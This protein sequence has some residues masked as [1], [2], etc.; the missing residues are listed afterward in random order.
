M[1]KG[2]KIMNKEYKQAL[3]QAQANLADIKNVAMMRWVTGTI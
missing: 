3:E 1:P 2:D